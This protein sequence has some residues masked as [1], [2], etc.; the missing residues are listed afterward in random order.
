M[1]P[2][3]GRERGGIEVT[4]RAGFRSAPADVPPTLRHAVCALVAAW[5]ENRE[6][7]A[8]PYVASLVSSYLPVRLA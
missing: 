5:Y 4:F 3:P 1:W 8:G 7:A 6:A 2:R